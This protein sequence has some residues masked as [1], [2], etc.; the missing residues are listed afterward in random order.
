MGGDHSVLTRRG[1]NHAKEHSHLAVVSLLLR[2][3][4][5]SPVDIAE[6]SRTCFSGNDDASVGDLAVAES[7]SAR[8]RAIRKGK[9]EVTS[10]QLQ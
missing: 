5:E 7:G 6:E 9:V 8:R 1:P 10:F 4:V 2:R 3:S